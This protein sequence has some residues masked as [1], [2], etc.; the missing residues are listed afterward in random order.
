MRIG[1]ERLRNKR[2]TMQGSG[3]QH[4]R[5][6]RLSNRPDHEHLQLYGSVFDL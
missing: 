2:S 6:A 4:T 1:N 3:Q 5:P